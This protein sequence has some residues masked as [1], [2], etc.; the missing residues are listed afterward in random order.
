M[1]IY[2]YCLVE[3]IRAVSGQIYTGIRAKNCIRANTVSA[4]PGIRAIRRYQT[5]AAKAYPYTLSRV[6]QRYSH[7]LQDRG[8]GHWHAP[9]AKA[10]PGIR[11][12]TSIRADPMHNLEDC[13]TQLRHPIL[14]WDKLLYGQ[15]GNKLYPGIRA[16]ECSRA[17]GQKR[18]YGQP[19][20]S[21]Y[22]GNRAGM[23][24]LTY[25]GPGKD[26]S[27][28]NGQNRIYG[29]PGSKLYPGIRAKESIRA[30]GQELIAGQHT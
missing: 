1:Y 4:Y 14:S 6:R 5:P 28:A 15:P 7:Q 27:R 16:K 17:A 25:P 13:C 18:L 12:I 10:Y 22:T 3:G 26:P 21:A 23:C 29:H 11:A 24:I 19:G 30:S 9:P 2:I 20:K 8:H